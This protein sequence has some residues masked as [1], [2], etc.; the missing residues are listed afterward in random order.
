MKYNTLLLICHVKELKGI[1]SHLICDYMLSHDL[2]KWEM[3]SNAS[4]ELMLPTN[5]NQQ[6]HIY[7]HPNKQRQWFSNF[8]CV[9]HSSHFAFVFLLLLDTNHYQLKYS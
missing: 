3:K 8:F 9:S 4:F 6:P 7:N 1:T 2:D 5:L